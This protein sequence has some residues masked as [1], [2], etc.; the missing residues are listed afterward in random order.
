MRD[1]ITIEFEDGKAKVGYNISEDAQLF[2]ALLCIEGI[3]GR[4]T[5]LGAQEI[6]EI[7]DDEKDYVVVKPYDEDEVVDTEVEDVERN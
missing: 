5:G 4:V 2:T 1:F 7:I 3:I 6:R